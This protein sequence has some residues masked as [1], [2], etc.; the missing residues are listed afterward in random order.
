MSSLFWCDQHLSPF[1]ASFCQKI[2]NDFPSQKSPLLS[3]ARRGCTQPLL[4]LTN[5]GGADEGPHNVSGKVVAVVY[6]LKKKDS[7]KENMYIYIYIFFFFKPLFSNVW[8]VVASN[9]SNLI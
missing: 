4:R 7:Q 9:L 6:L 8:F 1:F 2:F 3:E 5:H